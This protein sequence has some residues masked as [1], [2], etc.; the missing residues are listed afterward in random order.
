MPAAVPA[1]MEPPRS[2]SE[3]GREA[4]EEVVDSVGVGSEV[5]SESESES[6]SVVEITESE[7]EGVGDD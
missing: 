5:D 1:E 2:F 6:V 4:S 7:G 3:S